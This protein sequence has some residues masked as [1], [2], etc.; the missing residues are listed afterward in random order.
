MAVD[1]PGVV[2]GIGVER[3]GGAVVLTISDHL[4][5]TDDEPHLLA[6]QAKLNTY[7][8]F[9]ESGELVES[10][11]AAKGRDVVIDVVTRVPLSAAGA[12]FVEQA[13]SLLR[14]AGIGLRTRV[15]PE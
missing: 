11:P 15:L 3:D 9:V 6:L 1:E 13:M 10:Y 5:W 7:L 8:A 12:R 14:P 4:D 2:D